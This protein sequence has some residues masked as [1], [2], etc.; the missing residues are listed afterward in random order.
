MNEINL[1]DILQSA[2]AA[3][4]ELEQCTPQ[5]KNQALELLAQQ[6][7][8]QSDSIMRENARDL[9]AGEKK[10]LAPAMLDRL[11]L[12]DKRIAA[13]A[14]GVRQIATLPDPVGRITD[15]A[16]RPNGLSVGRMRVPIGVI[17]MIY[18]SRPNV[19]I[20]AAAL[21]LKAGNA[22]VLRGGSEAFH[23]NLALAKLAQQCLANA[24]LPDR[25]VQFIASTDREY[26]KQLLAAEGK[27]DA[28][29]PRGG[30]SL[31]KAV[32]EN[33]RVPVIKHYDGNCHIYVDKHAD[34]EMAQAIAFNA[35][36][37]RPGV[38]N[39]METLIVHKDVASQ[40]LPGFFADIKEAGVEVR[41][42][43]ATCKIVPEAILANQEDWKTEY[44]DLILAVRVV[45]SFEEARDHINTYGSGH[46]EAIVTSDYSTSQRFLREIDASSVMV[47]AST[48]FADGFEYGLGA[49]IGISTDRLHARGPMGVEELTTQKFI[50]LGEG[51]IRQ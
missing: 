44:L 42:C 21:C 36:V 9:E 34:L 37:Q 19:T 6:L 20:D 35:K 5:Q 39:A 46:T 38:C 30:K 33:A 29:I 18:E 11:K 31:V 41:G 45:D 23:S 7:G 25:A 16:R 32:V 50:V 3:T 27:I 13:M 48:R 28:V 49:E 10:N 15:L 47:N 8:E 40:F 26:V 1:D 2:R 24:G 4:R 17:G 43:E 14:E 22:I 12:D 51:H